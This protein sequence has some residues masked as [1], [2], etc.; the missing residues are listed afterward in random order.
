MTTAT[1]DA[2]QTTTAPPQFD[3]STAVPETEDGKA[4]SAMP[5]FDLASARPEESLEAARPQD[6][7]PEQQAAPLRQEA[8]DQMKSDIEKTPPSPLSEA[9]RG[10]I[11][12]VGKGGLEQFKEA[13]AVYSHPNETPEQAETELNKAEVAKG[14][15]GQLQDT[16]T[17]GIM[18]AAPE[19]SPKAWATLG[20]FM[21]ADTTRQAAQRIF[22]PNLTPSTKDVL[23]ILSFPAEGG[24]AHGGITAIGD[25]ISKAFTIKGVS[26]TID[27]S[28]DMLKLW[29]EPAVTEKPAE[30]RQPDVERM[31]NEGGPVVD[32]GAI[33]EKLGV[34]QNHVD[35]AVNRDMPVRIPLVNLFNLNPDE[36]K[37]I[38]MFEGEGGGQQQGIEPK[39]ETL[40]EGEQNANQGRESAQGGSGQ[41][42]VEG[43]AQAGVHLRDDAQGGVEA[44]A[45]AEV[46]NRTLDLTT[47]GNNPKNAGDESLGKEQAQEQEELSKPQKESQPVVD[48]KSSSK[49]SIPPNEGES[50]VS[51][52]SKSVEEDAIHKGLVEDL[53]DLPSYKTRDMATIAKKVSDFIDKDPELAKKIA[54]G[55]APEQD[56]IRSQELFTGLKAKAF[57]EGDV[58]LIHELGTNENASAM[59]TELGQR[60]KALDS[61]DSENPVNIVRDVQK[62]KS[63][64][65]KEMLKD[66]EKTAKIIEKEFKKVKIKKED[67]NS[68]MESW[69][70]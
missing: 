21:L 18:F 44:E 27:L 43:E 35:V 12:N 58:P 8:T 2:P 39:E 31:E 32:T 25:M 20:T 60:V 6:N 14:V 4:I 41:E 28:P 1:T 11:E 49:E 22:L 53:G 9:V 56:D 38:A 37:Q 26:P 62:S 64:P 42:G 47:S 17:M 5:P 70:C 48:Q 68:F 13:D 65:T 15:M 67:W 59:A 10:F 23:D 24:L 33:L 61:N 40:Q 7:L 54:L 3:L 57:K 69:K 30:A 66:Q 51:G 36:A 52:L 19:M 46:A 34:T 63:K 55:E 16:F 29:A 50:K 45:G